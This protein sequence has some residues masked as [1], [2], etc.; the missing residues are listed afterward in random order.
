MKWIRAFPSYQVA[1]PLPSQQSFLSNHSQALGVNRGHF[2]VP[3][4]TLVCW[5]PLAPA[6]RFM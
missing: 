1:K 5:P 6:G 3:R 2:D 4:A